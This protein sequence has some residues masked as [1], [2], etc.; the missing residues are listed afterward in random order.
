MNF[1]QHIARALAALAC[2]AALPLAVS[3]GFS[4]GSDKEDTVKTVTTIEADIHGIKLGDKPSAFKVDKSGDLELKTLVNTVL[5]EFEQFEYIDPASGRSMKY[6]LY[7]PVHMESSKRYPLV[8]FMGDATTVGDE[9]T[10]PLTQG[11]GALIWATEQWQ[12][13]YPAYVLVPQFSG[14]V[15]N[16][17]YERTDEADLA[18]RLLDYVINQNHVDRDRIYVTGQSMGGML[19]M[20]YTVNYP[21]VFAGSLFVDCHWN[22]KS[23]DQLAHHVF[24][25]ICAG[26]Q[27]KSADAL[28]GLEL[29]ARQDDV[30]Y[31]YAR[32]SARLPQAEQDALAKQLVSKGAKINII[33]FT[34]GS[35]VPEGKTGSE[36]MYSFDCAYRLTPVREWLFRQT[37]NKR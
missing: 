37:R 26:D 1:N 29:A 9:Y 15:V 3:C 25:F 30:R 16:D 36:H 21:N 31:E 17:K 22:P 20:Y 6:N 32:W 33:N 27:G 23:Y 7:T 2:C 12:R 28:K 11:F 4:G 8:M 19:A 24:T 14:V 5:P 35:V 18:I 34:P 13:R 10:T